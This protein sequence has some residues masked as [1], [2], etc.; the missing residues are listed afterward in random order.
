VFAACCRPGRCRW[1]DGRRL[2]CLSRI[3]IVVWRAPVM[4]SSPGTFFADGAMALALIA[5]A[6]CI[7]DCCGEGISAPYAAAGL[8][9]VSAS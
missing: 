1:P 5:N 4:S 3:G 7:T 6:W 9:L 2:Q 8:G